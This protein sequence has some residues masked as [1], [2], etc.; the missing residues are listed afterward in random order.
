MDS[1]QNN[2]VSNFSIY[3]QKIKKVYEYKIVK[4]IIIHKLWRMDNIFNLIPILWRLK[5]MWR[6]Y[7]E[8]KT[9]QGSRPGQN[10]KP[11][12]QASWTSGSEILDRNLWHLCHHKSNP[13][14]LEEKHH[15]TTPQTME[16]S[17][18]VWI[19]PTGLP[20]LS[21]HQGP[22]EADSPHSRRALTGSRDPAW[23]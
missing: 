14:N 10:I 22:G 11:S 9:V 1:L 2:K 13:D 6:S 12:S 8:V 16:E 15:H 21:R 17:W 20:P 19:L 23:F 7:Q 18:W 5:H 3:K 4:N